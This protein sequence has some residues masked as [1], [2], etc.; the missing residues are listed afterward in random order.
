MT[1]AD[2][3]LAQK[4]AERAM[5]KIEIL[6]QN[7]NLPFEA[8]MNYGEVAPLLALENPSL[9]LWLLEDPSLFKKISPLFQR[10]II[11]KTPIEHPYRT[12]LVE[13]QGGTVSLGSGIEDRP[14]P[15]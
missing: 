12:F 9:P 14:K 13:A 10:S 5:E 7:P 2:K 15:K 6:L 8:W 4:H 11:D 1:T 3:M